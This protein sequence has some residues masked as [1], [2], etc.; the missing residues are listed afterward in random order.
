MLQQH[1]NFLFAKKLSS[2]FLQ[3]LGPNINK[4]YSISLYFP[5][6]LLDRVPFWSSWRK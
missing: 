3:A 2:D 5:L 4:L 6:L 1:V